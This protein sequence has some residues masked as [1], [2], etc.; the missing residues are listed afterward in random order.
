MAAAPETLEGVI[1]ALDAK[2][3]GNPAENVEVMAAVASFVSWLPPQ[4][5]K[6]S[7]HLCVAFMCMFCRAANLHFQCIWC[8][9]VVTKIENHIKP[10]WLQ[11]W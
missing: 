5:L 8:L 11:A 9:Q 4:A 6:P 10:I 2:R 7:K 3:M 1:V